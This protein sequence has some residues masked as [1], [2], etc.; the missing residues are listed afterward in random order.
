MFTLKAENKRGRVIELTGNP[1]YEV[2]SVT[3]LNPP[4]ATVNMSAVA[5]LD[6]K[7]FNSS[8]INERN[9]VIMLKINQP[10]ESNRIA[11]YDYFQAK[12]YIKIYYSNDIRDVYAEGYIDTM[13]CDLFTENEVM[14]ISIMCPDPFFKDVKES[15]IVFS[16]VI[17]LLEF[18]ISTPREGIALSE[19][20]LVNR[21]NIPTEHDTGIIMTL[22][23]TG[24]VQSPVVYNAETRRAFRLNLRMEPG[25]QIIV[26]TNK[27]EK[28]VLL[29][30]SGGY[31]NII[32][33]ILSNPDW[34]QLEAGDNVF[35]YEA[36]SGSEHLTVS[37]TYRAIY[38]GV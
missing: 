9:V 19:L 30:R 3:G 22:T 25:D 17:D 20:D 29:F 23:A 16:Q 34:F 12:Q 26:N 36:Q 31:I 18:P 24:Y 21:I 33:Y 27:G 15:R 10:V 28:S 35:T 4:N 14:Q 5:N 37:I 7:F 2:M 8:K 1:S 11:I 32:N 38:E 13:E 6:G